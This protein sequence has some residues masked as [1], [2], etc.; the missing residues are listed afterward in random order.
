M[1]EK[2]FYKLSEK[3]MIEIAE[4]L[5][6][7]DSN[8]LFDIEYSDGVL[9]ILL[10]KTNQRYVINRHFANQK[11]WYSSPFS[12]ADYF[13]FDEVSCGWINKEKNEIKEKLLSEINA[14]KK[15]AT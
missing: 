9:D 7:Y 4:E 13:S 3:T 14:I 15:I 11:I 2:D 6:K 8:A 5:E 10:I 12:G 1:L